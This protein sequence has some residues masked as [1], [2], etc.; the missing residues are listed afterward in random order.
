[1]EIGNYIIYTRHMSDGDSILGQVGDTLK[2]LGKDVLK[3]FTG[4]PTE[5]VK[6]VTQ[7]TVGKTDSPEEAAKKQQTG[8]EEMSRLSQIEAEIAQIAKKREQLTGP[9]IPSSKTQQNEDELNTKQK[10]P[11]IDEASRQAVGRAEQ[12]RNFKG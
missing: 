12:G 6:T 2:D 10:G 3:Q 5:I 11:Q 7:Q 4:A 1:M 8:I 9:E